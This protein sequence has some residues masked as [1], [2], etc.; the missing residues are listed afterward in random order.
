V[1]LKNGEMNKVESIQKSF[2][3]AKEGNGRLH[4]LGLV[5]DG[6]VVSLLVPPSVSSNN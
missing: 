1:T 3:R 6:G 5:S 4:L 2:Q